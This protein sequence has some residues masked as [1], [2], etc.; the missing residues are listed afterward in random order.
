[1]DGQ[2]EKLKALNSPLPTPTTKPPTTSPSDTKVT[3]IDPPTSTSD[4]LLGDK[5]NGFHKRAYEDTNSVNPDQPVERKPIRMEVP[6]GDDEDD[7]DALVL[8]PSM[9]ISDV[10]QR[11]GNGGKGNQSERSKKWGVDITRFKDE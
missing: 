6:L 7:D 1:M 2:L 10:L 3:I 9:K 8:E 5:R 11:N 4:A